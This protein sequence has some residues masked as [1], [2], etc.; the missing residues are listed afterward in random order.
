MI[1]STDEDGTFASGSIERIAADWLAAERD[2][3]A[4]IRNPR[5]SEELA[6]D[7][8]ARYD[9]AV[10]TAR[11]DELKRAWDSARARQRTQMMGSEAWAEARRLSELLRTE[12][13]ATAPEPVES[14]TNRVEPA[15]EP[16]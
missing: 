9:E 7:L 15:A 13:E 1:R 16:A 10:R 5:Q 11:P 6:R 14:A 4:G 8:S 2:V 12:S 3:S